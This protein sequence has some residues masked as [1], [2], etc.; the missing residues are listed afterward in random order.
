MKIFST[1]GLKILN[2][3]CFVSNNYDG[4]LVHFHTLQST[5]FFNYLGIEYI[6]K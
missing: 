1:M 3:K 5:L 4:I 2:A 6:V